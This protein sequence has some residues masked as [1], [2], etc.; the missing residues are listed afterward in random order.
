MDKIYIPFEIFNKLP[1]EEADK[2]QEELMYLFFK[3]NPDEL[4]K[5]IERA[6]GDSDLIKVYKEEKFNEIMSK[7]YAFDIDILRKRKDDPIA[8]RLVELVNLY[9][10]NISDRSTEQVEQIEQ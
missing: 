6:E 7:E 3:D 4:Q 2:L 9:N 10:K 5:I 1:V 8:A